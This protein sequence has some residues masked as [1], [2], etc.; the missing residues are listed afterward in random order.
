[1]RRS[2]ARLGENIQVARKKRR[3]S[4]ADV[5]AAAS[6]SADTLRRLEAG[7]P[8]VSLAAFGMVLLALGEHR[9]IEKF[10]DMATDDT[11]LVID[12]SKLPKRIRRS[13]GEPQGL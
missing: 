2:L 1:M 10:L 3:M 11:G 7:D 13:K 6:I 9:R 4:I 12:V 8:G 5:T